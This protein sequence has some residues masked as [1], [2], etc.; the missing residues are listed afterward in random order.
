[1]IAPCNNCVKS[2]TVVAIQTFFIPRSLSGRRFVGLPLSRELSVSLKKLGIKSLGDLNGVS[3]KE[4]RAVSNKSSALVIELRNI[5]QELRRNQSLPEKV[6]QAVN[7]GGAPASRIPSVALPEPPLLKADSDQADTVVIPQEGRGRLLS[8]FSTSVRLANIFEFKKFRLL[9]ELHGLTYREIGKYRNCGR[10][11]VEELRG[12]VRSVQLSGSPATAAVDETPHSTPN[13]SDCFFIPSYAS[14]FSPLDLPISVRLANV[15]KSKGIVHFGD[16]HGR[17]LAEFKGL[18]NCGRR[19]LGELES[20]IERIAAGEFQS[21]ASNFSPDNTADLLRMIDGGFEKLPTQWREM[22]LLRLGGE[23]DRCWTLEEVGQKFKLTRERIR[24]I[25]KKAFIQIKKIAG[26]K[27]NGY[28]RGVAAICSE[29]VCPLSPTLLTKWLGENPATFRFNP[30]IYVRLI[31]E[32]DPGIPVWPRGQEPSAA[33][34]RDAEISD[35][36]EKVLRDGQHILPLG[37]ALQRLCTRMGKHKPNAVEFLEALKHSKTLAVDFVNPDEAIV[38]LRRLIISDVTRAIL[39]PSACPLTPEEILVKAREKFG[40]E[41]VRWDARTVSN[42]FVP[43]KGFFLLGPR[44]YGLRQ[45]FRLPEKLWNGVR[46]DA[47]S[48]LKTENKPISTSDMIAAYR[49][50]WVSQTNKYEL[51]HVL[52][53]NECFVDLGRL[54]FGLTEWGVEEREYIKDLIPKILAEVGRPMTSA[55][56]LEHLHRLRSVSPQGISSQLRKHALIRDFGFGYHGLKSWDDSVKESLV[57]NAGLVEKVVRRSDPPLLFV[58]LC[59]ILA[60]ANEGG[61]ADK[62]WQTCTSLRS[63]VRS[64]DEQTPNARLFHKSCTLERALVVTARAVGRPLPL[65]EFQ[66][67]LNSNF[68]PLFTDRESGEIRRCLEHS[69]FFL[70]DAEDQFILDVH[71][72]SLG[73]DE[74]AIRSACLEILAQSSEVIGCEDLMERLEAEGKLWEELSPDIL[75]SVLR[76]SQEFEEVGQNRFRATSCKH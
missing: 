20:L 12:L 63:V 2:V 17:G 62:L 3:P 49:F 65:Y 75:G 24:Q 70:R 64:T 10:R 35:A 57:T 32:L 37:D 51:A 5:I 72:D 47:Q 54:L 19:T 48:L 28:L 43:E 8:S 31:G 67:E 60:I 25:T 34:D 4:F 14:D 50:D 40:D 41:I 45:H 39:L 6:S 56:I 7:L 44:C 16:L 26:P 21:A 13:R 58:R 52:R 11:T 74:G 27:M 1:M 30:L 38:R 22:L 66:W 29:K 15:L 46:R 55:Q 71:L 61:L 76:A 73:L 18:A 59:E 23:A 9:G 33:S 42:S 69:R 53:E 36:A 68:S